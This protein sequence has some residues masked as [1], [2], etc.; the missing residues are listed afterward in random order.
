MSLQQREEKNIQGVA[1]HS[2]QTSATP[3]QHHTG[4]SPRVVNKRVP[5]RQGGTERSPH[6]TPAPGQ[7]QGSPKAFFT[8]PPKAPL[9]NPPAKGTPAKLPTASLAKGKPP[10]RAQRQLFTAT[11]PQSSKA[12]RCKDLIRHLPLKSQLGNQKKKKRKK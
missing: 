5:P 4:G 10:E 1:G 8:S 3:F 6:L 7:E 9:P 11:V 12:S 2:Q